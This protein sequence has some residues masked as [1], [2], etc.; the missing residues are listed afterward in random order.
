VHC[1]A[2]AA[3][4]MEADGAGAASED[5]RFEVELEFV[6]CLA[7]PEYLHFLAQRVSRPRIHPLIYTAMFECMQLAPPPPPCLPCVSPS[8]PLPPTDVASLHAVSYAAALRCLDPFCCGKPSALCVLLQNTLWVGDAINRANGRWVALL[9]MHGAS[10][11]TSR[12]SQ[13]RTVHAQLGHHAPLGGQCHR[14]SVYFTATATHCSAIAHKV[15]TLCIPMRTCPRLHSCSDSRSFVL[16]CRPAM[17][18]VFLSSLA[19]ML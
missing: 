1:T 3:A 4:S 17:T 7:N 14:V 19:G 9:L 12:G 15:C 8:H 11:G 5:R 16:A 10:A 13:T 2:R 18:A 6:Q